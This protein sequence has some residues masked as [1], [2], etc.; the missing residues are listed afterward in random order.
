MA[1]NTR[2]VELRVEQEEAIRKIEELNRKIAELKEQIKDLGKEKRRERDPDRLSELNRQITAL[3]NESNTAKSQVKELEKQLDKTTKTIILEGDSLV[4][5]RNRLKKAREEFDNM[6]KAERNSAKGRELVKKIRELNN[7][8]TKLE[9]KTGRFQR[10]VGNYMSTVKGLFSNVFVSM[11]LGFTTVGQMFVGLGTKIKAGVNTTMEYN[12]AMSTLAAILQKNVTQMSELTSQAKMLGATTRYTAV[13]VLHLQ[14]ELA[15]LGYKE[16]QIVNMAESV[17]YLA[18]ATGTDLSSA[19]A[20]AGA[21]LR[22][23]GDDST[24][25][26]KYVDQMATATANSAMNFEYIRVA[27]PIVGNAAATFGFSLRDTLAL[28]GQLADAGMEAS[29]AAT[30]TRNILL[31][32]ADTSG[33]LTKTLGKQPKTLAEL[34][35]GLRRLKAEG[36][37]LNDALELTNVR[38]AGAFARFLEATDS[39]QKLADAM[40]NCD[41]VA[42]RMAETMENNLGGDI[43]RLKSAWDDLMISFYNSQGILRDIAQTITTIVSTVATRVRSK[44]E[45]MSNNTN[46]YLKELTEEGN[47]WMKKF[48]EGDLRIYEDLLEK[49]MKKT[50]DFAKAQE[51]AKK[52]M[53]EHFELQAESFES[54]VE[55]AKNKLDEFEADMHGIHDLLELNDEELEEAIAKLTKEYGND[56]EIVRRAATYK[57]LRQAY[58]IE[59]AKLLAQE[60]RKELFYSNIKDDA[61]RSGIGVLDDSKIKKL[62]DYLLDS[63][64]KFLDNMQKQQEEGINRQKSEIITKYTELQSEIY[65]K[66]QD[67]GGMVGISFDNAASMSFDEL[68]NLVATITQDVARNPAENYV[69][70]LELIAENM[71]IELKRIDDTFRKTRLDGEKSYYSTL[72]SLAVKGTQEQFDLRREVIRRNLDAEMNDV[73]TLLRSKQAELAQIESAVSTYDSPEDMRASD[74]YQQVLAEIELFNKKKEAI[75]RKYQYEELLLDDELTDRINQLAINSYEFQLTQQTAE[76]DRLRTIADEKYEIYKRM[77]QRI[78]EADEDF[79]LR[80]A[81]SLKDYTDASINLANKEFEIRAATATS[82]STMFGTISDAISENMEENKENV[83][84]QKILSLASV[85]LAQG[86]AIANAI[87]NA[88]QSSITVWDMAAQIATGITTVISSTASAISSIKKAQFAKGAVDIQGPGT[89]T[90]DSIPAMISRGESVMTAKATDMFGGLLLLMNKMAAQPR[91]TLPTMYARYNPTQSAGDARQQ[92]VAFRDAVK[93]V[94]PV[95]SV[96]DINDVQHRVKVIES[97]ETI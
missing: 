85:Y 22:I 50:N 94:N 3:K 47:P 46:R 45:S 79:N 11:A 90:S 93:E 73:D 31:K 39:A 56:S 17:L 81:K 26:A 18:Q 84:L 36:A 58:E 88:S 61:D 64:K 59:R 57:G 24:K 16:P 7:E 30:A 14:T 75:A 32:L 23:F 86:V 65:K 25:T 96:R 38:A 5:L 71:E 95:V 91:V 69:S 76:L 21:A 43:T 19:A 87:K 4:A 2:V 41:G 10:N 89:T 9:Q 42:K 29:M 72:A 28:V 60:T 6:S 54:R 48:T 35:E 15:K 44:D 51:L 34:L 70:T 78:G 82:I 49:Y 80:R 77:Y 13:E 62:R 92:A 55:I 63:E 53:E 74:K 40:D 83:R 12:R 27:L 8:I 66:L 68:Y 20:L 1:D 97:L 52:A 37:N 33:L 67:I